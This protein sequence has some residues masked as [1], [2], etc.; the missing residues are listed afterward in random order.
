MN[1]KTASVLA[2]GVSVI[3]LAG[4]A[5]WLSLQDTPQAS[6]Q[7]VAQACEKAMASP[8]FDLYHVTTGKPIGGEINETLEVKA[9]VANGDY[10][11]TAQWE[12]G[13]TM[14]AV[15]MGGVGYSH[16][17]NDPWQLERSID[18]GFLN[19]HFDITVT[20]QGWSICPDLS[21]G[22]KVGADMLDGAPMTR[23]MS[24][25]D[26]SIP[27]NDKNTWDEYLERDYWVDETGQLAQVRV[28][29]TN[30]DAGKDAVGSIVTKVTKI[31]GVGETNVITAPSL[32]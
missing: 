20:A 17:D 5:V 23:Y 25:I 13:P 29:K 2:L 26:V 7:Q 31:I 19:R 30:P 1:I 22:E 15:Y 27:L 21:F 11:L 3:A 32:P 14:E 16:L 4:M 10:H 6:A 28:V 24:N 8:Y 9:R 18:S 12:T